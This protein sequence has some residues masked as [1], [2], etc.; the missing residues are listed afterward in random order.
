M[1]RAPQVTGRQ[2]IAA[3]AKVG[4][5]QVRQRG[6]HVRLR[7]ED[8]RVTSVPVHGRETLGVGLLAKILRD[9]HLSMDELRRLL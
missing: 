6:S 2:L 4:F 1:S 5:E 7:H 9:V 8:G 3:L